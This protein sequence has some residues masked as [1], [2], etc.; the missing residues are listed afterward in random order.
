MS[1]FR[2]ALHRARS[3]ATLLL[4]SLA[5]AGCGGIGDGS[6]PE[7][8]RIVQLGLDGTIDD[9]DVDGGV[10]R[11]AEAFTCVRTAL[12]FLIT[13]SDGSV[14]NFTSRARWTS[15][16]PSVASVSNGDEMVDDSSGLVFGFGS[17]APRRAGVA[18][19]NAEY[20]G[21]TASI[22]VTV[23]GAG[24]LEIVPVDTRVAPL[25]T[26]NVGAVAL[27]DGERVNV[28]A[29][30]A[31]SIDGDD[32]D[33]E[34][35]EADPS[36]TDN[37]V[38]LRS[39]PQGGAQINALAASDP[40]TIRGTFNVPNC[41][42]SATATVQVA[43]IP[44]LSENPPVGLRLDYERDFG[45]TLALNTTQFLRLVARFGDFNGDGDTDDANE[46]QDLS[47]LF[48][49]TYS[50]TD[51]AVVSTSSLLAGRI[52]ILSANAVGGPVQLSAVFGAVPDPDGETGPE[53]AIPGSTSNVLPVTV[54]D[55]SLL[56]LELRGIDPCDPETEGPCPTFDPLNPSV[57]AGDP[58]NLVAIAT[59]EGGLVQPLTR[60]VQWATGNSDVAV[61]G[62]GINDLA[63]LTVTESTITEDQTVTI[64]AVVTRGTPEITDDLTVTI[65]LRVLAPEPEPAS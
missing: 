6:R 27:L 4:T 34:A 9:A 53:V 33:L 49:T 14:G 39:F 38:T 7:T 45:E 8:G 43:D 35:D 30:V 16:D 41:S 11:A 54:T 15:S 29:V 57:R 60:H 28:S 23:L 65:P 50:S 21:I 48:T 10:V 64:S 22:P 1:D 52:N 42:E 62:S 40:L 37:F 63:G 32:D 61:V 5:V 56:T 44:P 26:Q 36:D 58:I 24:A 2:I 47:A 19:I 46:F 3:L 20:L 51:T 55:P 59:Y 25:T 18:T 12:L 13:F 31:F 17:V